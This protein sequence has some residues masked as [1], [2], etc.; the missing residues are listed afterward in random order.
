MHRGALIGW[1]DNAWPTCYFVPLC[2]GT[3]Q[4][5][6]QRGA[7]ESRAILDAPFPAPLTQAL[8]HH[9]VH[10]PPCRWT[11]QLVSLV[12]QRGT[13]FSVKLEGPFA[14]PVTEPGMGHTHHPASHKEQ[15]ASGHQALVMV[16]GAYGAAVSSILFAGMW[17]LLPSTWLQAI[18]G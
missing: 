5:V 14:A 3:H 15:P 4:L 11:Q 17:H 10:S 2:K 8:A 6:Q 1:H 16:A 7:A 13:G 12:Q 18:I 9:M